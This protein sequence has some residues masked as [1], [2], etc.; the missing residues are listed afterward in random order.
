MYSENLKLHCKPLGF[1]GV[2]IYG[3]ESFIEVFSLNV[4]F[5][6]F[7]CTIN[8]LR[9]FRATA[10]ITNLKRKEGNESE[11]SDLRALTTKLGKKT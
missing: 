6:G 3:G 1:S 10:K 2:L 5:V 7:W 9:D 11:L 8:R 4:A